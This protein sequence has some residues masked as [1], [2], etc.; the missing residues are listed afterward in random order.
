MLHYLY[1]FIAGQRVIVVSHGGAIR[2]LYNR[3][4]AKG[5][6]PGKISNTS[7]GI[8]QVSDRDIWSVKSWNDVSHLTQTG[9][10]ESAFGGDASSG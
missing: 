1:V 9:F 7:V 8:I 10:L 5:Q 4:A 6:R 3:A 2:S